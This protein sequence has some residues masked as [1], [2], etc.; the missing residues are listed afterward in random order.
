[1][2]SLKFPVMIIAIFALAV[3]CAPA[4]A[5][6]SATSTKAAAHGSGLA[7]S[8]VKSALDPKADWSKGPN[9]DALCAAVGAACTGIEILQTSGA[10]L[11]A[12]CADPPS[13]LFSSCRC[14][15]VIR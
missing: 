6:N 2:P 3:F 7:C 5:D 13:P 9:C 10:T 14:C 4:H 8:S 11:H 1:M 15:A 12:T